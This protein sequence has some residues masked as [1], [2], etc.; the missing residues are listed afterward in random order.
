MRKEA[1]LFWKFG[2]EFPKGT[3][4]FKEGDKNREMY[5]ILKGKVKISRTVSKK[6]EKLAVISKGEFFG[7]MAVL[8]NEPRTA[9]AEVIEPSKIL[10]VDA[11]TFETLIRTHSEIALK[12]L[13]NLASRLHETDKKLS[14][15]SRRR[16]RTRKI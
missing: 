8:T 2:K 1:H 12:M 14:N 15:L 6:E 11:D 5:V 3:I 7:E 9:T 10:V 13:Q 16:A 4:L